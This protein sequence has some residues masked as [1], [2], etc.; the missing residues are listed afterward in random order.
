MLSI[1]T[2]C[3]TNTDKYSGHNTT[4]SSDVNSHTFT[5]SS[6]QNLPSNEPVSDASSDITSSY[7]SDISSTVTSSN[8]SSTNSNSNSSSVTSSSGNSS[9]STSSKPNIPIPSPESIDFCLGIV[10]GSSIKPTEQLKLFKKAGFDAFFMEYS[11]SE[12]E[13]CKKTAD[14]I[15]E[16]RRLAYVGITRAKKELYMSYCAERMVFGQTKRPL[17][18]RFVEE[19]DKTVCDVIDRNVKRYNLESHQ[20]YFRQNSTSFSFI[21]VWVSL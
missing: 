12:V 17:P 2:G 9:D 4:H 19:I 14:E 1:M 8:A 13:K 5:V 11:A 18:S 10:S 16:E 3:K 6:E 21:W 20:F 15:E 7:Q